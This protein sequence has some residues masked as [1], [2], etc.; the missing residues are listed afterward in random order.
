MRSPTALAALLCAGLATGPAL[1]SS[2]TIIDFTI[3]IRN[4]ET[5]PEDRHTLF[6]GK[7]P[8]ERFD[9]FLVVAEPPAN[10]QDET[11][12]LFLLESLTVEGFDP[13]FFTNPVARLASDGDISIGEHVFG[14]I[15]SEDMADDLFV[16]M[17]IQSEFVLL[18]D[19]SDFGASELLLILTSPGSKTFGVSNRSSDPD[20]DIS[21]FIRFDVVSASIRLDTTPIPLPA[22]GWLMV[23]GLGGLAALRR[24]A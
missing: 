17:I 22:A 2:T 13:V 7:S 18:N 21:D 1:A 5:V 8:G 23:A 11:S 6:T 9:G 19:L 20:T 16:D 10:V 15:S 12:P 4:D 14:E 24:R 3:E